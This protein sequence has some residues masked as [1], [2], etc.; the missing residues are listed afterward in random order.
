MAPADEAGIA[1][2]LGFSETIA[3]IAV[4][5]HM[6]DLI[7]TNGYR[8]QKRGYVPCSFTVEGA[9]EA[10]SRHH[11]DVRDVSVIEVRDLTEDMLDRELGRIKTTHLDQKHLS[12]G[13]VC[14]RR[15]QSDYATA[16]CPFCGKQIDE[17]LDMQ[18]GQVGVYRFFDKAFMISP[19]K[20]CLDAGRHVER[21]DRLAT[22]EKKVLFHQTS[23]ECADKIRNSGKMIRGN[24]GIAGSGIY[25]AESARETEWKCEVKHLPPKDR[26]VLKCEVRLGA[27]R[28]VER[29]P[30][31]CFAFKDLAMENIDSL[32][33]ERGICQVG[34]GKGKPSGNEY[35]VF[36]WDQVTVLEP[37]PRDPPD[38]QPPS[39]EA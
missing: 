17:E 13:L 20:P 11:V 38:G 26:V 18:R 14:D 10:F 12:D 29:D 33:I 3:Y 19:C 6:V 35:V 31:Q 39:H 4:E 25:F 8:P 2:P 7:L 32:Y 34:P 9:V 21:Q 1:T 37:V 15:A 30:P 24:R 5:S 22:R 36:S 16:P 23:R 28:C 27:V